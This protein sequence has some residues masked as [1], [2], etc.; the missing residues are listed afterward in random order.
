MTYLEAL[1]LLVT[2]LILFGPIVACGFEPTQL[3]DHGY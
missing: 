3:K 1:G 2:A